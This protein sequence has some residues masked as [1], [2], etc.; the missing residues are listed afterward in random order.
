VV[1]LLLLKTG[2]ISEFS[3]FR[4]QFSVFSF[5]FSV[6]VRVQVD[7]VANENFILH[8]GMIPFSLKEHLHR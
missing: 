7:V 3:V 1:Q 6:F 4:F 8:H 2:M 5:P